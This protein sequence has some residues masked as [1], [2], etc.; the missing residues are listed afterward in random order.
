MVNWHK[1]SPWLNGLR[2]AH[3]FPSTLMILSGLIGARDTIGIEQDAQPIGVDVR[4]TTAS[5][6]PGLTT[7]ERA[8]PSGFARRT[9][10]S[11]HV[12]RLKRATAFFACMR[13][14]ESGPLIEAENTGHRVKHCYD[15]FEVPKFA[16]CRRGRAIASGVET[17]PRPK[18]SATKL[19]I[20]RQPLESAT[21]AECENL[22][23]MAGE[24]PK[25]SFFRSE[26][27]V[28]PGVARRTLG[29]K[30]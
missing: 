18:R 1:E 4:A 17:S 2:D 19:T 8:K 11:K 28:R 13:P 21:G 12:D 29:S 10:G 5:Q 26:D 24:A 14:G 23:W 9:I 22:I 16:Y 27:E 15:M 6:R 30:R 20:R 25:C 3:D 7:E